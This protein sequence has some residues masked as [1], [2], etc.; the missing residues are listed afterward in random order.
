[1]NDHVA[2]TELQE[3]LQDSDSEPGE[4]TWSS[5]V[6]V[7]DGRD[8][9][10]TVASLFLRDPG[11]RD[12]MFTVSHVGGSGDEVRCANRRHKV[13]GSWVDGQKPMFDHSRRMQMML[14]VLGESL[15]E[16][17][18]STMGHQTRHF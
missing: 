13:R 9:K 10:S 17:V 16:G 2:C 8:E 18:C 12:E 5:R 4:E 1:M 14:K 6:E 7:L 15:L 3:P 11:R